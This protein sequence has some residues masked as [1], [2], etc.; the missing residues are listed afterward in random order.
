[1]KK[2]ISAVFLGVLFGI[3]I[4]LLGNAKNNEFS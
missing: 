3:V 4:R 1:M 2:M